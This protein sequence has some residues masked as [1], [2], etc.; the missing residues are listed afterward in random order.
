MQLLVAVGVK[1]KKKRE[2][3]VKNHQKKNK[4]KTYGTKQLKKA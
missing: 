1:L 4:P 2:T 3:W